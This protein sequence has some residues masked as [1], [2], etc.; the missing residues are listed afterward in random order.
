[1]TEDLVPVLCPSCR[2]LHA[3]GSW[4]TCRG[5]VYVHLA[6]AGAE[7]APA[8][9]QLPRAVAHP[10]VPADAGPGGSR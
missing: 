9:V 7:A 2:Q 3:G 6:A 5:G 8:A 10:L 4:H 1:M